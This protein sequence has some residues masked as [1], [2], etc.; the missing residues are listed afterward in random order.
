MNFEHFH[1]L[2]PEWFLAIIPL[3]MIILAIRYLHK[4]QS[5]WNSVLA[6]HL[7]QHLVTEKTGKKNRPPLYLLAIA[8]LI[9]VVAIAGPTWEQLPQPVYQLNTGKVVVID[10]S[11]SMRATDVQPDRLTRAKYKAIDL[12][13]AISEGETG[14]VAYSG[15]AFTIS[16]L[17][18][19]GQNLTALIP[20]LIPEIMP[21]AGSE[22]FLGLQSAV[23]LLQNAGFQQGEIFWITDGIET[24]QISEVRKL[25]SSSPYRLSILAVG[26]AQ[27]AP[28]KMLDGELMKDASGAIVLPRLTRS[29]LRN[30]AAAGGGRFTVLQDTDEDIKLLTSQLTIEREAQE[31]DEEEN[32]MGD[33]WKE[34]GPY[35]VLLLLPFAAY[36]FRRGLLPVVT[37]C[38]LLPAYS[39]SA[40]ADWWQDLW[41]T[42]DQQGQEAFKQEQFDSA[43]AAFEDPLW[44]GSALYKN[45]DYEAALDA[46]SQSNS[47]DSLYNSGNTLAQLGDLDKAIS[48]Y[49][50]VLKS[51]PTHEDAKANKALLEQQK[52]Q[53]QQDQENQNQQDSE[54]QQNSEDQQDSEQQQDGQDQQDSQEQGQQQQGEQSDSEQSQEQSESNPQESD[55]EQDAEQQTEQEKQEQQDSQEQQASEQEQAN[56]QPEEQRELTDEEKEQMQRLQNLLRKIPD[57]PGYLLKQK[58]LREHNLRKRERMPTQLQRN[59]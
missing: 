57:D 45:G 30:L 44:K 5:G 4:Q 53:Q 24:E 15:D 48:A 31:Q 6:S 28:I 16:P 46:F 49:D 40:Q 52:Q 42:A 29:S 55:E 17:S 41:K 51:D 7:Y 33:E 56:V 47:I 11:L 18:T 36:S 9:S 43:A 39:P 10:M 37:V 19:D 25:I 3:V 50:E 23:E 1:F 12:V 2:R 13:N 32:K 20:S 58:M 27:G 26:T 34:M 22:P 8:W 59:W 54:Q 38:F 14:L 21:V 35:L